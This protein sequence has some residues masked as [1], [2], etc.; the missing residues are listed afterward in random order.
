MCGRGLRDAWPRPNRRIMTNSG[1]RAAI[2]VEC[3]AGRRGTRDT[4]EALGMRDCGD[5]LRSLA[6]AD[7]PFP[8]P[9]DTPAVRAHR[10]RAA[11][12]LGPLLAAPP[13]RGD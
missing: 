2:R 3:S 1:G 5:P 8:E 6:R 7:P 9:P 11:E 13:P 12:L 4:I 10:E